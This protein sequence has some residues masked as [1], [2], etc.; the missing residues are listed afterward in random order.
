MRLRQLEEK[1]IPFMLEWMHDPQV[2]RFFRFD[3]SA[4]NEETALRFI[5]QSRVSAN[6]L[7]YACVNE[8]DEYLGTVSLKEISAENRSAEFAV[9]FRRCAQGTGAA[10]FA[11]KELLHKAFEELSLNRV[12]LNVLSDNTRAIAFYKKLG[13]VYEGE[14][15][16]HLVLRE[17]T[18]SLSWYAMLKGEY[19]EL[20]K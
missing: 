1:D 16:E 6:E 15:R 12:Y 9:S 3:M 2:N 8:T 4:A 5:E 19:D 13:F 11:V 20:Y 14:F 7:H 10:A 18:K 17:E